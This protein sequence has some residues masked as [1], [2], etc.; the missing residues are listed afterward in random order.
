[1]HQ[2]AIGLRDLIAVA[3]AAALLLSAMPAP[4]AHAATSVFVNPGG[5]DTNCNGTV[6]ASLSSAPDC[7][8]ASVQKGVAQVDSGGTVIVASGTY[9]Q[10]IT[11]N[12]PLTLRGAQAQVDARTRAATV[13]TESILSNGVYINAN[14]VVI[15]GFIVQDADF[16]GDLGMGIYLVPDHS[17]YQILNNVIQNNIFGLYLNASG[18]TQTIVRG[19][20][21]KNNNRPGNASGDA[22][23]SELGLANA[24]IDN[25]A[26]VGNQHA[27]LD[28]F[29]MDP[30]AQSNIT[31]SNN[32]IE[33][34]DRPLMLLNMAGS[35]IAQNII[36]NATSSSEA[37]IAIYGG[38]D[39]LAIVGNTIVNGA[40][41]AVRITNSL[42]GNSNITAHFNRIVGNTAGGILVVSGYTGMLDAENNWW[43]CNAGP[44][45][46]GCDTASTGVD[47]SPW[48]TL[49]VT[50][51]PRSIFANGT[52][53]VI[54]NLT[55]NSDGVNTSAM[56]YILDRTPIAFAS[57]LGDIAPSSA[58]TLGGKA[59]AIFA[60]G[61]LTGTATISATIDS[62]VATTIT[63]DPKLASSIEIHSSAEPAVV[64]QT[65]TFMATVNA[66]AP[67]LGLPS[68]TVTFKDGALKLGTGLLNAAGVA[69]FSTARLGLGE[70]AIT[71]SYGGNAAFN[72]SDSS[73]APLLQTVAQA[74]TITSFIDDV[75]DPSLVGQVVTVHFSVIVQAPGSGTPT[76]TATVQAGDDSCTGS[77]LIGGSG[78]CSLTLSGVGLKTLMISYGGDGN[79]SGSS[80]SAAH[81]VVGRSLYIPLARS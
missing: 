67:G 62:T 27:A 48:L 5:S 36:A 21:F 17:G 63:I 37:A 61:A 43:G 49:G 12:K 8:F 4:P 32:Q 40:G 72:P 45:A 34:S 19:N 60:S 70:H 41:A 22:I 10:S 77:I 7:A 24:L 56:G 74:Q 6:D 23:Y 14:N 30:P 69:S 68:G 50:T 16:N 57:T 75:P 55:I 18:A 13:A 1:M 39:G 20:L 9:T 78:S 2:R 51:L 31:I 15:D 66:A 3:M 76:G 38:V 73:V 29:G 44:G 65:I 64:G 54:A 46:A 11:I 35:M 81:I 59:Q 28:L 71:A 33:G 42:G 52:A 80:S 25:N 53:T 47:F 58:G 79:Y 26:F